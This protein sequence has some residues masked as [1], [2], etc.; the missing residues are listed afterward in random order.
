MRQPGDS[1]WGVRN[2]PAFP[3][4]QI[5]PGDLDI[6]VLGQLPPPKFA[7][8]D[9]FKPGSVEMVGFEAA[10]GRESLREQDLKHAPGNSYHTLVF[11]DTDA[12]L[13]GVAVG[14]PPGVGW[15]A[16]EHVSPGMFCECSQQHPTGAS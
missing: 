13:D 14:V 8:S 7:L 3:F 6:A 1:R 9:E 2:A 5:A 10:F 11:A 16:E 15:E 4:P 12:E